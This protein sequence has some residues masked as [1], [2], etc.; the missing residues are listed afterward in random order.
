MAQTPNY[1]ELKDVQV[2]MC[3]EVPLIAYVAET[4][5]DKE[6][7]A[8]LISPTE[9]AQPDGDISPTSGDDSSNDLFR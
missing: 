9:G 6:P 2:L 5:D 3:S 1:G 7:Q 4:Q 8:R